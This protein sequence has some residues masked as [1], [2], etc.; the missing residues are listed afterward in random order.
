MTTEQ[1]QFIEKFGKLMRAEGNR[2]GYNIISTS[3]AQTIIEG[4]WGKSS[5]AKNYHNHWGLK[6]G[7]SWTGASVNLKT[8]EEYTVGTLTTISDN[9]RAYAND[10]EG[11]KG[12]YDFIGMQRYANLKT[13]KNYIEFAQFLKQD[14]YATSSSYVNTLTKCV[15]NYNLTEYDEGIHVAV[16]T[17]SSPNSRPILKMSNIKNP[18]IIVVQVLLNKWFPLANITEDNI[19]GEQTDKYVRAFQANKG[20]VV[21]GIVGKKTWE[22]LL[23]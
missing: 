11:V 3:L 22:A 15:E 13:A 7:K 23:S 20:L 4:N 5:L 14:G 1:K 9:F 8:K 2:R 21:D 12:Y 18:Y 10:E 19:F 6:C 16:Q 17:V